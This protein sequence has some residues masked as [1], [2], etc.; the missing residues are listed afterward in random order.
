VLRELRIDRHQIFEVAMLRAI[1]DHLDLAVVLNNLRLD[2][3][4]LLIH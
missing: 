4:D 1:L 3:A 2:L